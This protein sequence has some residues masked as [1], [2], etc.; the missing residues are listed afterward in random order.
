MD[1]T[2]R[3]KRTAYEMKRQRIISYKR[4]LLMKGNPLY[5]TIVTPDKLPDLMG[6][7][8][9]DSEGTYQGFT[10]DKNEAVDCASVNGWKIT[11]RKAV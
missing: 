6:Y 1:L 9:T 7:E 8:L 5:K 2:D 4:S 10:L 11:K 3:D